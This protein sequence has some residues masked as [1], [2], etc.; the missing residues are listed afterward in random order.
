MVGIII[1]ILTFIRVFFNNFDINYF[2]FKLL[3]LFVLH[4]FMIL[5]RIVLLILKRLFL[6]NVNYFCFRLTFVLVVLL[7]FVV[8]ILYHKFQCFLIV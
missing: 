3:G 1:F 2:L 5:V 4:Y 8:I 6:E 7:M